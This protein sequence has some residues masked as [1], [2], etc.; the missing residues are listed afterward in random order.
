MLFNV[1]VYILG[2]NAG[3]QTSKMVLESSPDIVFFYID[4][5]IKSEFKAF[6]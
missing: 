6:R 2:F 1:V 5:Q 4:V 3:S